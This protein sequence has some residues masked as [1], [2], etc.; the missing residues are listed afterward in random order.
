MEVK[1]NAQM[2]IEK[3]EFM[4]NSTKIVAKKLLS[5]S[6]EISDC[7]VACSL[8]SDREDEKFKPILRY[9]PINESPS[10]EIE[11]GNINSRGS[12]GEN[13]DI[14]PKESPEF[15]KQYGFFTGRPKVAWDDKPRSS[16]DGYIDC[17]PRCI[18]S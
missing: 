4:L 14:L 8:H 7:T 10:S 18:T 2:F 16:W 15:S 12:L 13:L 6:S 11:E 17:L 5:I 3:N 1:K 9:S